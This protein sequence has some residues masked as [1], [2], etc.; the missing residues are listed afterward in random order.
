M[1]CL[2]KYCCKTS[3]VPTFSWIGG[4]YLYQL[5]MFRGVGQ[6]QVAFTFSDTECLEKSSLVRNWRGPCPELTTF[7]GGWKTTFAVKKYNFEKNLYKHHRVNTNIRKL[8]F[9]SKKFLSL[10]S[11]G[12]KKDFWQSFRAKYEQKWEK[13]SYSKIVT[14]AEKFK[15]TRSVQNKILQYATF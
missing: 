7:L 1:G 5:P 12:Q 11:A 2:K 13:D 6:S 4:L 10:K 3:L 15:K 14:E 9:I 8:T